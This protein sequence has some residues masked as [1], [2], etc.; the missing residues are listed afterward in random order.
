MQ[1]HFIRNATLIIHA[2]SHRFLVDPMLGPQGRLPPVALFRHRPRRNPTVPL[3]AGAEPALE[4]VTTALITHCHFDHLD[5]HGREWLAESGVPAY[6][7]WLDE[8]YLKRR[9]ITTMPLQIEQQNE[10][11][12]GTI[13][14]FPAAHGRGV[15][16]WLMGRGLSYLVELPGEPSVYITGDTVMTPIVR[17]VLTERKPTVAVLAAG[18]ARMDLGKSILMTM[19]E[20]LEFIRM[21]PGMVVATHMEA[22]NHC[23]TTRALLREAVTEAGLTEKVR[24]PEDGE[25]LEL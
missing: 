22:L 1:I 2:G 21:S 17:F 18:S 8:S 9:G 23:P 12:D 15:M 16:G 6:C 14:P 7:S 19:E 10:F 5:R 13:T 25:I 11:L 4:G 3:P 24:I 20:N